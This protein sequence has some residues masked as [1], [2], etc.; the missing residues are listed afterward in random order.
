MRLSSRNADE[1][2]TLS[3]TDDCDGNDLINNPHNDKFGG[4]YTSPEGWKFTV[5]PTAK[6]L[7]ED[8][9]DVSYRLILDSFE[10]CA[11]SFPNANLGADGGGL[12]KEIEG[13]GR[14]RIVVAWS[15]I[16]TTCRIRSCR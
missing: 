13:C 5:E 10:V 16:R 2:K 3:N 6:K 11:R 15:Y 12:K 4:I 1:S 7:D 14:L 9:Y 8:S